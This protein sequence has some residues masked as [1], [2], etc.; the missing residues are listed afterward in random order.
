M[1]IVFIAGHGRMVVSGPPK[2][3]P[4]R[5]TVKWAVKPGFG[6]SPHVSRNM[7]VGRNNLF[8]TTA[9]AN[10]PYQEHW[11]MPDGGDNMT[12]KAR[13][14]KK[15][16][17]GTNG[18]P[19]LP[20]P[21]SQYWLLQPRLRNTVPLSAILTYLAETIPG[22]EAIEVRWTCC[23]SPIGKMSEKKMTIH[24]PYTDYKESA[25]SSPN[26]IADPSAPHDFDEGMSSEK[27]VVFKYTGAKGTV[28]LAQASDPGPLV[29][30]GTWPGIDGVANANSFVL[31]SGLPK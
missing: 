13:D 15:A 6:S 21:A 31:S 23:R 14:L 11:L 20:G 30:V 28:T 1:A 7:I 10:T 18:Y 8:S 22:Q 24:A 17:D 25:V 16:L 26:V 19:Q 12:L 2:T 4:A 29:N 5:I 3:V 27:F 9:A